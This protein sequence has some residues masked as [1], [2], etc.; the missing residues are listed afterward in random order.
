MIHRL[1]FLGILLATPFARPGSAGA[2]AVVIPDHT[3]RLG[4]C[5]GPEGPSCTW[6]CGVGKSCVGGGQCKLRATTAYG[7]ALV[8]S[9]DK[10]PC[11]A[12]TGVVLRFGLAGAS[13]TAFQLDTAFDLC[14]RDV[15][16]TGRQPRA[17][18]VCMDPNLSPL[19]SSDDGQ[20]NFPCPPD[21][22]MFF[23]KDPCADGSA[24]V[25]SEDDLDSL[26]IWFR[27]TRQPF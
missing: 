15:A 26:G 17:C 12:E 9:A 16:C 22:V 7:A 2:A 5:G 21:D 27:E 14:A 1:L 6:E 25:F 13:A 20:G 24:S 23:C 4:S 19:C 3:F 11:G 18:G 10:T 8:A